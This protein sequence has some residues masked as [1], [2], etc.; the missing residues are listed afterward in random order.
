[1]ANIHRCT[2]TRRC[3]VRS[4]QHVLGAQHASCTL[5]CRLQRL[6]WSQ[7]GFTPAAF[8]SS[9][10]ERA[11]AVPHGVDDYMD[12]DEKAERAQATIRVTVRHHAMC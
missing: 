7:E 3:C 8:R 10:T 11:K 4:T 5:S 9:R 12:E 1:M 2:R 6:L